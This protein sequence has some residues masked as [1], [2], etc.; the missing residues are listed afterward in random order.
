M[1]KTIFAIGLIAV[2]AVVGLASGYSGPAPK[3]VIEHADIT[4][5]EAP[6]GLGA[7]PGPDIYQDVFVY[8]TLTSKDK[9]T[10]ITNDAQTSSYATTTL[11]VID[12]GNTYVLS[13]TGTRITLPAVAS[14]DGVKF[15]FVI[16]GASAVSNFVVASAE[17][18]NVEGSVIVAGAVV[19]CNAADQ[20]N[21]VIDGE[22]IGDFF[23]IMSD[24]TYWYPLSSGVLT[25]AKLTCT[26]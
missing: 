5:N 15:R 9:N 6:G 1:K 20:L 2:F 22:N 23:E 12:S 16:G 8:G 26:G 18:D 19:D 10:A 13:G 17:G 7:F 25:A 4:V 11:L 3:A 14:S 21:F 24:G